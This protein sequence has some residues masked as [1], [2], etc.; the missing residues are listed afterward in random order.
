MG[1]R[2]YVRMSHSVV[3]SDMKC[4]WDMSSM[5]VCIPGE[6]ASGYLG[7]IFP[8]TLAVTAIL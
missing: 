4:L 6:P 3:S 7:S 8:N 2:Y 1:M 5:I